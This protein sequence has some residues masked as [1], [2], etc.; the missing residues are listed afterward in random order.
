VANLDDSGDVAMTA[1]SPS[2]SFTSSSSDAMDIDSTPVTSSEPPAS[3]NEARINSTNRSAVTTEQPGAAF[4]LFRYLPPLLRERIWSFASPD[5]RTRFLEI[6]DYEANARTPKIRY[7]PSLPALFHACQEAR[8][9]SIQHEGGILVHFAPSPFSFA[10]KPWDARFYFNFD[11]DIVFLSS[12]FKAS[13]GTTETYRIRELSVALPRHFIARVRRLLITYSGLDSYDHI[14]PVLRPY[15]GLEVLYVGM[16]D[17]WSNKVV[18]RMLR[19]GKPGIGTVA[20]KI[21]KMLRETEAEETDDDDEPEE[22]Y[23]RRVIV[24]QQRRILEVE[25]RLDEGG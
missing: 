19:K 7:I 11:L 4:A 9:C 13:A 24:R 14:G 3:S 1:N 18:K 6:Y 5:P 10:R 23:T 21:D 12:R 15:A 2:Q 22:D 16:M 25:V 8:N 17:W 20:G